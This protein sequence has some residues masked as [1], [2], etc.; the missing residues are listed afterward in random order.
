MK[1]MLVCDSTAGVAA[2][3]NTTCKHGG[4][5]RNLMH[6]VECICLKGFAGT[7]CEEEDFRLPGND[8]VFNTFTCSEYPLYVSTR[9]DRARQLADV[10]VCKHTLCS[11]QLI[12]DVM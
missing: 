9:K 4:I 6:G 10:G 3:V 5:C 7:S 1:L 11:L 2:C 12:L 8:G